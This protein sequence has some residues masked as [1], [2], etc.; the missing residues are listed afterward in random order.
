MRRQDLDRDL[1]PE[2]RV[3]RPVHLAHPSGA[4]RREDLVGTEATAR[5]DRHRVLPSIA[6]QFV[7][8]TAPSASVPGA[9]RIRRNRWPSGDTS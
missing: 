7:T 5:R 6:V 3:P 1:P 2:T 4:Q 8:T 9:R